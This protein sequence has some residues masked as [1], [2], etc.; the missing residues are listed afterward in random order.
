MNTDSDVSE[1][2]SQKAAAAR[3]NR[4]LL[5]TAQQDLAGYVV[6]II[7]KVLLTTITSLTILSVFLIFFFIILKAWPYFRGYHSLHFSGDDT[8]TSAVYAQREV[9]HVTLKCD[10]WLKEGGVRLKVR[11]TP[12]GSYF[13]ELRRDRLAIGRTDAQ[14][15]DDIL[16]ERQLLPPDKAGSVSEQHLPADEWT[17][18]VVFTAAPDYLKL[19]VKDRPDLEVQHQA[20][21]GEGK[22]E[23]TPTGD[24]ANVYVEDLFVVP[25]VPESVSEEDA[26][27]PRYAP[28]QFDFDWNADGWKLAGGWG[29]GKHTGGL[30]EMFGSAKWYPTH[31]AAPN[32]GGLPLFYGSG[33]V[34]LGAMVIAVPIGLMAA[35]FLSDIVSFRIRQIVKP[36]VEMLAAIPSV[37]YGFFAVLV[38]APWLQNHLGLSSGT[39]ALNAS[40]LLAVMAVPTIV[41]ISEDALS[42]IGR[43]LR[44]GAYALGS[45]RAEVMLKVVIPA[46]HSG[47][48][49]A[50]ILGVMRAVGET[51]LVWM[52]AGMSADIPT[53]WWDLTASVR[54]LTATIAQEMG[55]APE[56]G[57]HRQALF[58]TGFALLLITFILNMASEYFLG[59][60]KR[61]VRGKVK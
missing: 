56:G 8:T 47:I 27:S 22:V 46:A 1:K 58:A 32:F 57:M 41:S 54:T 13:A 21:L 45:T 20:T 39:N 49:A 31:D 40:L 25:Y 3:F 16:A 4:P 24:K 43:D 44:E 53:P 5:L 36:V 52:A 50:V 35:V 42:A 15:K 29:I 26:E 9:E 38:V 34:T 60:A 2:A 14:G 18:D 33:I 7:G 59:R 23:I 12:Q 28:A 11:S 51:M 17:M 6:S 48:I 37:A 19:S 61:V 30:D 10:A 55:E